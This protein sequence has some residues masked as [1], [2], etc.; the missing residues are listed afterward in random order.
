VRPALE[1]PETEL[2]QLTRGRQ[3][4]QA[5]DGRDN[6]LFD[7]A[8]RACADADDG[9]DQK[10]RDDDEEEHS[11]QVQHGASVTLARPTR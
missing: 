2:T 9:F 6:G 7:G 10:A 8:C 3:Y 11:Q 1:P 5:A 4:P